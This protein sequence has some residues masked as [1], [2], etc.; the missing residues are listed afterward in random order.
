LK[1]DRKR[2]RWGLAQLAVCGVA[3]VPL[4]GSSCV[5]DVRDNIV[6]GGLDFVHDSVVVILEAL[7]PVEAIVAPG[8]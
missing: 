4:M 8:E 7:V 2:R 3:L 6:S 5:G 1:V